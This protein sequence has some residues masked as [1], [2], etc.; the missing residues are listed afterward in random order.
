VADLRDDL[1]TPSLGDAVMVL[2]PYSERAVF[3]TG[4]FGG[5]ASAIAMI[6]INSYRL[7]RLRR[8]A[9]ILAGLSL[10]VVALVYWLGATASGA[11]VAAMAG[12]TARSGTRFLVQAAGL[13]MVGAGYLM[14][15]REQRNAQ[16]MGLPRP[17]GW[18]AAIPCVL[19]NIP[20]AFLATLLLDI[21]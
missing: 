14:H 18:G 11:Q 5:P 19:L 4:F 21:S 12:S 15:R 6:A 16:L 13:L 1:L 9:L 10:A 17:N 20:L 3:M 7:R 8:D 2:A